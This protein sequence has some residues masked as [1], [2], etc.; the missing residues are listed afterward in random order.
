MPIYRS[1]IAALDTLDKNDITEMKA[2]ANPAEEI[3][4]VVNSVCLLL[5][6]RENWDEG[7]KLKKD[8]N[9][10]LNKLKNYDKDNIKESLLKKLKNYTKNPKFDPD[11]IAKKSKAGKSLCMWAQALDNYSAVMKVIKP[12]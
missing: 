6:T 9:D 12:K 2:Y 4:M 5:G 1:A 8:P 7:K 11:N 3:V 10:F